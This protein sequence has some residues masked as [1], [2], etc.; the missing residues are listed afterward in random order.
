MFIYPEFTSREVEDYHEQGYV[1][2]GRILTATGLQQIQDQ[3]MQA[4]VA[5]KGSF[6][7]EKTWIQNALLPNIHHLSDLVRTYYFNGPNSVPDLHVF[8]RSETI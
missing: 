8:S 4:W 5:E 3:A 2:L 7:P 6:D 1:H